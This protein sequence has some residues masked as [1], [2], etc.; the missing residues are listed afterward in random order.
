MA[1]QFYFEQFNFG[2]VE[3]P[4]RLQRYKVPCGEEKEA[5]DLSQ[6]GAF[7]RHFTT[8]SPC[9]LQL[10]LRLF[11]SKAYRVLAEKILFEAMCFVLPRHE[12][13]ARSD[14]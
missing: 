7:T 9:A 5:E 12:F 2:S 1:K 11:L 6:S 3:F 4:A 8:L 14:W 10:S 13:S